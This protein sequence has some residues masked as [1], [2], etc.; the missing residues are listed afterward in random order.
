MQKIRQI[1]I[2][3][4]MLLCASTAAEELS[5]TVGSP[6]VS[7][8]V[9]IPAYPDLVAV[10]GYPVYYAPGL[11]ANY[12][13][14]DGLYWVFYD[15]DWYSSSWYD[16]PWEQMEPQFVPAYILR[17]PVRYYLRPP[18]YFHGW[19]SDAPPRWGER[20]GHEWERHRSGWDRWDRGAAPA[21][22]PLPAYQRDYP[23]YRY[24]RQVEQ[25]H[26]LH[27]QKYH[28]QPRDPVVRQHA[29]KRAKLRAP[30]ESQLSIPPQQKRL[31]GQQRSQ[32]PAHEEHKQQSQ[33]SHAWEE[34]QQSTGT[35]R[36]PKR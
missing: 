29:Q 13:F 4:G 34:K 36:A 19:H 17:V 8:G 28:H 2:V 20:W 14:Y 27:Q 1:L 21:P 24:P 10:P 31:E 15:D 25:Q 3:L 32:H 30:E 5:I 22:A 6:H 23:H 11:D 7:I 33:G 16:G 18:L 9:H 12:F 35:L 26:E